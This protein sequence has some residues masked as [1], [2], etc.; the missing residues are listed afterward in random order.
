VTM[1]ITVMENCLVWFDEKECVAIGTNSYII[2]PLITATTL[3]TPTKRKAG[4]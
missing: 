1:G 3:S 2:K 4:I